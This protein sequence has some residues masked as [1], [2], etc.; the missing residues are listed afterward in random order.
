MFRVEYERANGNSAW[1]KSE[2]HDPDDADKI[3]KR[4]LSGSDGELIR[5]TVVEQAGYVYS[6]HVDY[7][8]TITLTDWSN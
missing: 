6:Q 7:P 8:D 5:T 2:Y 3:A 1:L 4:L